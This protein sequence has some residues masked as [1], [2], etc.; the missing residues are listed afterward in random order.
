VEDD[1]KKVAEALAALLSEH[2]KAVKKVEELAG[3]LVETINSVE[4]PALRGALVNSALIILMGRSMI[5]NSVRISL[6][7][8]AK[9]MFM[10][11]Q[12]Q[13]VPPIA[14]EVARILRGHTGVEREYG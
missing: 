12:M 2:E 13:V 1:V 11:T 10:L 3:E 7:E 5:E 8:S 6:L 4:S 9:L 14:S